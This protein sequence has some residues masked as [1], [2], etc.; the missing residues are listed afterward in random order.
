MLIRIF[1]C[2]SSLMLWDVLGAGMGWTSWG[3]GGR[4]ASALLEG[5]GWFGDLVC[6]C[7]SE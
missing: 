6:S 3:S 4:F 1:D 5:S 7:K 2:S